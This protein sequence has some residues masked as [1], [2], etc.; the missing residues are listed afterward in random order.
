MKISL[1]LLEVKGL[2]LAINTADAMAKCAAINIVDIEK[3]NGNGWMLIKV[4]G[5]VAAVQA[6]ISSGALL[7]NKNGGLVSQKVLSRPDL[8]LLK[9][10]TPTP[11]KT[12]AKKAT[13]TAELPQIAVEEQPSEQPEQVVDETVEQVETIEEV[14]EEPENSSVQEAEI[15]DIQ[16]DHE[17]QEESKKPNKLYRKQRHV[18]FA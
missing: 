6:A 10:F 13:E 7:A 5:D 17:P 11:K 9:T 12:E 1:G 15:A 18:I 14:N 8:K 2:A 3:T 16:T 4:T